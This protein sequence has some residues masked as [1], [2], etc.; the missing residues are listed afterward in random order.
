MAGALLI[1]QNACDS[2]GQHGLSGNRD[3]SPLEGPQTALPVDDLTCGENI[4]RKETS[5]TTKINDPNMS[6]GSIKESVIAQL[7]TQGFEIVPLKELTPAQR[8]A[9]AQANGNNQLGVA[10]DSDKIMAFQVGQPDAE[11]AQDYRIVTVSNSSEVLVKE[12]SRTCMNMH[13]LFNLGSAGNP[14]RIVAAV[15][16]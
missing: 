12:Y 10:L 5:A 14:D 13:I 2:A 1:T 3:S 11:P 15:K 9:V 4:Y 6:L 8:T 16:R 7:Q